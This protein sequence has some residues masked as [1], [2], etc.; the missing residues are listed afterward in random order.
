[1]GIK[2]SKVRDQLKSKIKELKHVELNRLRERFLRQPSSSSSFHRSVHNG[3]H[4]RSLSLTK[5]KE[6]KLFGSTSSGK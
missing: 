2:S 5:L 1:M 3:N 4:L 6:R